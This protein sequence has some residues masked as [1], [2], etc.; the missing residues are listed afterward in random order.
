MTSRFLRELDRRVV[1]FD[2][3]MGATLQSMPLN[4]AKDYLG[5]DN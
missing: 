4:P 3:S 2:G 5:R 1:V